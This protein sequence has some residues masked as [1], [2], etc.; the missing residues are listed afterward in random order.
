MESMFTRVRNAAH[1]R[2]QHFFTALGALTVAMLLAASG[3][4]AAAVLAKTDSTWKI[5]PTDPGATPWNTNPAFDDSAWQDATVLA[6]PTPPSVANPIWSSTGQYGNETV[7][8][9]R[10]VFTMTGTPSSALLSYGCDDDCSIWVNGVQVVNDNNGMANGGTVD[11]LAQLQEGTNLVAFIA[12]DNT[13]FGLNH[14][15]SV[16]IDAD[17]PEPVPAMNTWT[18]ALSAA[19]LLAAAGFARRRR[20]AL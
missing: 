20:T 1:N 12:N 17:L 16:Q 8:W 4:A 13:N 2:G 10:R 7:V 5:T 15:A 9:A 19:L 14:G 3:P 11:V 6:A 18:L